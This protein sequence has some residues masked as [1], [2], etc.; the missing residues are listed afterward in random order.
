MRRSIILATWCVAVSAPGLAQD[1]DFALGAIA[2]PQE[3]VRLTTSHFTVGLGY[4]SRDSFHVARYGGVTEEGP[5]TVLDGLFAGGAAWDSDDTLRWDARVSLVG[6]ATR[7]VA[8]NFGEQGRWRVSAFYSAFTRAFTESA[9]TPYVGAGTAR[10]NLPTD[11]F[12]AALSSRFS[13]LESSLKALELKTEWQQAGAD[14]LL[15]PLDG[16]E[17][18][19]H[20]DHRD[21]DGLRADFVT[22]GHESNFPVGVFYPRPVDYA[23]DRARA[24]FSYADRRWQWSLAYEFAAFSSAD[25]DV[26]VQNPYSRSLGP[27]WPAGAQ[28]GYPLAFGQIAMPPDSTAHQFTATMGYALTSL[29]RMTARVAYTIQRQDDPFL[30]YTFNPRL[31]VVDPLPRTSLDGKVHKTFASVS[32]TAREWTDVDLTASYSFDHRDNRTPIALY[33]YIPNDAQDQ[34]RPLIPGV[35]R[36][37]R[38]DLPHSFKIHKARAEVGYRLAPRTRLSV[39]YTGDFT[40]RDYQQVENSREHAVRAKVLSTFDAGSAWLAASIANRTG[41]DYDDAAAWDA[42]HTESYLAASPA[43]QSIEYPLLRRYDLADRRRTEVKGGATVDITA[44]WTLDLSGGA[45]RDDYRRSL[46]GL[47]R[48][49]WL[50]ADATLSYAASD[51]AT[52]SAFYGFERIGADQK[53]YFIFGLNESNPD[54]EWT[55]RSRERIHTLGARLDWAAIENTLDVS[56]SGYI[57]RGTTAIDVLARPFTPLASVAPLPDAVDTTHHLDLDVA[58]AFRP[59]TRLKVGYAVERRRARDWQYDGVGF[60]SISQILGSGIVTPRYT[61][62]IVTMTAEY[63]F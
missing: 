29:T 54:Q 10:L 19:L 33:N 27:G 5:F 47:Q 40:W 53:G 26:V 16:Y 8:V 13:T 57:T 14:F 58:Y 15:R 37:I 38:F 18:R 23:S 46:F 24:S 62:H 59:Q 20:V 42:S 32:L 49:R 63:R 56:G 39:V 1:N 21:R 34:A 48:S 41:S 55:A 17:L 43:N 12:G 52:A 7:S 30:D 9:R 61:V 22:F 60:S 31:T 50:M 3:P 28:A 25:P 11:W 51:A 36:Y 45:A 44:G 4:Q 35:S 2:L 6:G